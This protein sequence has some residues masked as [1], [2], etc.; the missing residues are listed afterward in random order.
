ME[1]MGIISR[2]EEPMEWCAAIVMVPKSSA[3]HAFL[4][5]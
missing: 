1:Q 4:L 2:V 5:T 3:I